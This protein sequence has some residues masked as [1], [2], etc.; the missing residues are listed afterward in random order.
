[1]RDHSSWALSDDEGR[2]NELCDR[3]LEVVAMY[4]IAD[5]YDIQPL[6]VSVCGFPYSLSYL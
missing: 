6:R 3:L 1:M 5:K 2:G 4:I